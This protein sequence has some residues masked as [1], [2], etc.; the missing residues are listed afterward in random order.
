MI[1]GRSLPANVYVLRDPRTN[2]IRYIGCTRYPTRRLSQHC[3]K[4]LP[5]INAWVSELS[6]LGMRPILEV[7]LICSSGLFE[8]HRAEQEMIWK[9]SN[10]P[11][12]QLLNIHGRLNWRFDRALQKRRW[13]RE[14]DQRW[15]RRCVREFTRRLLVGRRNTK[16]WR[17]IEFNGQRK[18][19]AEWAKLCGISRERMRQ[20]LLKY[21]PEKAIGDYLATQA[22]SQ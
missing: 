5:C 14:H 13:E 4:P 8:G 15:Y 17:V 9:E 2:A 10:R 20:R 7:V 18:I 22:A 21:P 1:R 12:N 16:Q 11:G 3:N 19:S 6:N